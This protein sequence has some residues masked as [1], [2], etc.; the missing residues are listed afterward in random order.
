MGAVLPSTVGRTR[1]ADTPFILRVPRGVL[2]G[3]R[4]V[5]G[6]AI[7]SAAEFSEI[8]FASWVPKLNWEATRDA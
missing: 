2:G 6:L 7:S 3:G 5:I 8:E 4:S 1:G